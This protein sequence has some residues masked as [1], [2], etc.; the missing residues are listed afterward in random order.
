MFK[1]DDSTNISCTFYL[2]EKD[3][4]FL[5]IIFRITACSI[6]LKGFIECFEKF[7]K[8]VNPELIDGKQC[9]FNENHFP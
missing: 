8:L 7:Y 9:N 2:I 4:T 3:F 6:L 1:E 5:L